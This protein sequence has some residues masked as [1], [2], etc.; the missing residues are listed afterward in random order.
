MA[1]YA[2]LGTPAQTPNTVKVWKL[3]KTAIAP[4]L[5]V[6]QRAVLLRTPSPI[7][8]GSGVMD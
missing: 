7:T 3:P 2:R 1:P 5:T 4:T 6:A 8:P